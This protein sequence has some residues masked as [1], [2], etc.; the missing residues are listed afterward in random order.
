MVLSEYSKYDL[1]DKSQEIVR[2]EGGMEVLEAL[3]LKVF[4]LALMVPMSMSVFD[5]FSAQTSVYKVMFG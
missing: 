3:D 4:L 5:N 2:W 1:Y